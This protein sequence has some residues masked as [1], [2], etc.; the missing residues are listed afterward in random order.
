MTTITYCL[1]LL[2]LTLTGTIAFGRSPA[3]PSSPTFDA[4]HASR[5]TLH[6]PAL[7][8]RA[9]K[10]RSTTPH[11]ADYDA[12]LRRP[13]HRVDADAMVQRLQ[14]LGVTTHY[15]LIWHAPTDWDDLKLF[16]P[17]AAQANIAVWVYLVPPTEGP[18]NGYPASEPFKLDYLRWAQ[19]I[20]RLSLQHTNLTG[21]VIDDFYANHKFFTPAYVKQMQARAKTINPRLA[22]LPLMYFREITAQFVED[23]RNAIDGVVVAYPRDRQDILTARAILNGEATTTPAGFSCPWDT[24]THPG[25]HVTAF[26]PARVLSTR[27]LRLRFAAEDDFSGPTAG[28][29]F[30]QVLVNDQVVWEQDVADKGG[31]RQVDLDLAAALRGKTNATLAFR[32]FDKKGVSNF[33]VRWCLRDLRADGL[34]LAAGLDKPEQWTVKR[35]G[36]FQAGFANAIHPPGRRFHIPF[37]VMTAASPDE[38]KLRHGDPA[39][40]Q[41]IADWLCLAL[42]AR[43][44]GYCDGVVTYCLDKHP[45][46]PVFPLAR[47]LF[48]DSRLRRE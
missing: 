20:A 29:H 10:P 13:D 24:P 44:D 4:F 7:C 28:Y 26:I 14:D 12:E 37:I 25:D 1:S 47:K 31:W 27:H 39:S 36:P 43:H 46:S 32:L 30:K 16:L 23:Y 48:R 11:L 22:F 34:Q 17:K 19:E 9:S 18:P 6:A 42:Q 5:F 8:R 41:R 35:N 40:P 2:A 21:W 38:F 15:W 3:V 45:Q 33:G